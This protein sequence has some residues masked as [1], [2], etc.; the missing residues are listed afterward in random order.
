MKIKNLILVTKFKTSSERALLRA[1]CIAREHTAQLDILNVIDLPSNDKKQSVDD[2]MKELDH[3]LGELMSHEKSMRQ[4]IRKSGT[5]KWQPVAHITM[6]NPN[7]TRKRLLAQPD[8]DFII[9]GFGDWSNQLDLS[10]F[11]SRNEDTSAP[12]CPVWMIPKKAR[13]N[14]RKQLIIIGDTFPDERRFQNFNKLCEVALRKKMSLDVFVI[15]PKVKNEWVK[16]LERAEVEGY[17]V[18]SYKNMDS[19]KQEIIKRKPGLLSVTFQSEVMSQ[20]LKELDSPAK[21]D[22]II[23]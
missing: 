7:D 14:L 4:I 15:A 6:E 19:L 13:K 1:L 2:R 8:V 12:L 23:I 11:I 3:S 21:S 17:T 20:C 18:S 22:L 5:K 10:P 16:W 9:I